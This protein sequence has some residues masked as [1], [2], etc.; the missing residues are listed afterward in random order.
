MNNRKRDRTLWNTTIDKSRGRTV[1][2]YDSCN[3][4]VRKEGGAE[5]IG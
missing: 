3:R 2:V 4:T 5:K 1:A